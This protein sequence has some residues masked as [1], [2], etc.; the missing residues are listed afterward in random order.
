MAW[1]VNM[2]VLKKT[3]PPN[4]HTEWSLVNLSDPLSSHCKASALLVALT[5]RPPSLAKLET[6]SFSGQNVHF[7]LF[8]FKFYFILLFKDMSCLSLKVGILRSTLHMGKMSFYS[9][10]VEVSKW[11]IRQENRCLC[12]S[13]S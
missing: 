9:S 13:L 8:F 7:F 3:T 2:A 6:F 1:T 5:S 11:E 10:G 12:I 4:V